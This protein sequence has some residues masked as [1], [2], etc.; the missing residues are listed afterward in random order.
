MQMMAYDII[1]DI[2]GY[3]DPLEHLLQKMGYVS[4]GRGYKAPY[5]RQAVFV[6]DLIDRGPK[7]L[8][9][10]E[11]VRAMID[12][13]D[14]HAVMGNHEFNAVG[15][16]TRSEAS[17]YLRPHSAKNCA[18]HA[19]FLAQVGEGSVTH[20]EWVAWFKTLPLALDLIGIRIAHAWW[21]ADSIAAVAKVYWDSARQVMSE[22]F[23]HASYETGS[24]LSVARKTLTCG[25]EWDLP[26][27][28]FIEDKAG[29]KHGEARLAVWRHWAKGLR[30]LALV[31]KGNEHR[32]P[33]IAIPENIKLD[34]VN[35]APIF[36]GHHWFSGEPGI[37]T[38]KV[39]CL[40]WSV[41]KDG[42]LVAYRWDGETS[43]V[44]D[45]L[46]WVSSIQ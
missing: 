10:L 27:G 16:V 43:L 35:G 26:E 11:I 41:A 23:L 22:D 21:D 8:R 30:E 46:V 15:F 29:H 28:T 32:V 45:N 37:E 19:D 38:P 7:Q 9:V 1:G 44:N 24:I 33:D 20:S 18:Q 42:L 12:A 3:A 17:D 25:I 36:I 40:D 5:G 13:G 39:A 14:A 2:H 4:Q 6:G 31:P 34:Q